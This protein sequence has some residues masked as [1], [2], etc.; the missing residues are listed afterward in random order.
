MNNKAVKNF[1]EDMTKRERHTF[2][3]HNIQK[4]MA[5]FFA[6][7]QKVKIYHGSTNSTRAQKFEEGKYIDISKLNQVVEINTADKYV[8]VEPNVSMYKLVKETARYNL[9][10][11]VV[12]EFPEI[13]VGGG[14]QGGAG[15]SS[16]FKY[17]LFHDTCLEYEMVLGNGKVVTASPTQNKD[18]FYGTACSYGSLGIIT[19]IKLHLIPAKRFIHITYNT[20]NSVNE[21][22]NIMSEKCKGNIDFIDGIIFT[23]NRVTIMTGNF[24]DKEKLPVSTFSKYTD[25]WFYLHINNI[26]KQY[27]RYE[28]IIPTKDYLFRYD[29]GGFWVGRYFFTFFKIPFVKLTRQIFHRLLN[30]KTIYR[31]LHETNISQQ[32]FVQDLA[33]PKNNAM[34][35]IQFVDTKLHIYP[36]W[37]CPLRPGKDDKLSP[38]YIDTN[39]VINIGVWGKIRSNYNEFVKIHHDVENEVANL[40]GRKVLYA[41]SYYSREQFWSIYD[42]EW[43]L[44]LRNKYFADAVFPDIYEKTKVTGIYKRTILLGIWKALTSSKLSISRK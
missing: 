29:M 2:A 11:P 36:L 3:I 19:L 21:A 18:L 42:H 35:F 26:S 32:Y 13:T 14:I 34:E 23:K 40:G 41:H 10:P 6:S 22:I 30:T 16:S 27:E 12:M 25:E 8:L 28:E 15:E 43:Y 5:G 37:L 9:V 44:D 24:S 39:L 20:V 38:N 33:L 31:L 1:T 7:E 4:Q 17:G